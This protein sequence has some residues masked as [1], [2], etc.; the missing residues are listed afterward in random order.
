MSGGVEES[1]GV[2]SASCT[3]HAPEMMLTSP[4]LEDWG[5]SGDS[6]GRYCLC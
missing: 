3:F 2:S 6:D 4:W 1:L 5:A